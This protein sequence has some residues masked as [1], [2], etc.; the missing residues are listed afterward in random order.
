MSVFA[1]I[2]PLDQLG[3]VVL[4]TAVFVLLGLALFALAFWLM[5]KLSPFSI[6]KELEHDHNTALAIV[7]AA[8]IIGIS[9]IVASAING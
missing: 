1:L 5:V 7:M 3:V 2:T 9:I 8:V 4:E 6:R